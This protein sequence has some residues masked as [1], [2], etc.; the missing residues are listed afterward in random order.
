MQRYYL[1]LLTILCVFP[2]FLGGLM[3]R[4]SQMI[5]YDEPGPIHGYIALTQQHPIVNILASITGIM[6]GVAILC[7]AASLTLL[8]AGWIRQNLLRMSGAESREQLHQAAFVAMIATT[9]AMAT[10]LMAITAWGAII[11][12]AL[13]QYVPS[14]AVVDIATIIATFATLCS[15]LM[16]GQREPLTPMSM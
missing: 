14:V 3:Y 1:S 7:L 16:R 12:V 4:M 5:D 13:R 9:C 15:F 6:T 11:W 10:V 2:F 8:S